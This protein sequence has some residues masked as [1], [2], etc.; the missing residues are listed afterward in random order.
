MMYLVAAVALLMWVGMLLFDAAAIGAIIVFG[1]IVLLFSSAM[2]FGSFLARRRAIRQDSLLSVLA[3]ATE[4]GIP[5]APAVAAFADQFRG[6]LR[7]RIMN[8]AA[9]LNQGTALAA[10]L[11]RQPKLASRNAVLLAWVGH[12]S[13]TLPKAL[14]MATGTRSAQLPI[15][16]AIT[17]RLSYVIAI[18]LVAQMISGFILYYIIPKFEAIFKD[19]NIPLP[20][21]TILTIEASHF[22]IKFGYLTAWLPLFELG[23]LIFLPLSFLGWGNYHIP[24]FDR[25]LSRRHTALVLRSLSLVVEGGK[26][27]ARGLSVV[28][29][30]YPTQW[31]RRR[32]HEAHAEVEHGAQ[33]T[34]AL[35][36]WRVIRASDAEVLH[37]AAAVGNLAW[38]LSE[39]ADTIER[40]LATRAHA[41]VQTLFPLA[42]AALGALVFT[43][44]VAYFMPLVQLITELSNL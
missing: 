11:E 38:A 23:L 12:E 3:I 34:D 37:S 25:L 6:Q 27:L 30:H 20:R 32:L 5:L 36:R 9:D 41:I 14:R 19:F 4:R 1:G 7:W 31:M 22:A 2:G 17:A 29:S 33:W 35:W 8:L 10:A 44:A 26:P 40:R 42:V 18:L 21:V 39:L 28:A 13:G 16:T 15:W 43:L 24:V